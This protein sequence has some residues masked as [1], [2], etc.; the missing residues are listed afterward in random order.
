MKVKK[1]WS[2]PASAWAAPVKVK[3]GRLALGAQI[4]DLFGDVHVF[5]PYLFLDY[6]KNEIY[7]GN[8]RGALTSLGRAALSPSC[9]NVCYK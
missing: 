8:Y 6:P 9:C 5:K 2:A 7:K 4:G 3:K 1:G